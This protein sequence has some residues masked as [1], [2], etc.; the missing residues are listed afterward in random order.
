MRRISLGPFDRGWRGFG[1]E[2]LRRRGATRPPPGKGPHYRWP[3]YRWTDQPARNRD[4]PHG[5]TKPFFIGSA[6]LA[7]HRKRGV[8]RKLV[9][10]EIGGQG[11]VPKEC[12]LVI[13]KGEIAGRVTSCVY[14]AAVGRIIG[15]AYV[16]PHRRSQ[17]K[18]S[19]SAWTTAQW[20]RPTSRRR[21]STIRATSG[22]K[23]EP[24]HFDEAKLCFRSFHR[25]GRRC[26]CSRSRRCKSAALR[27]LP[28]SPVGD[29]GTRYVVL[30]DDGRCGCSERRQPG[31]EAKR[32]IVGRAIV[33]KRSSDP[34]VAAGWSVTP[35]RDD[36]CVAAGRSRRLLSS[37]PARQPLLVR[38]TGSD[39][40]R[41][42]AKLC[43]VNLASDKFTDGSVAQTSVAR[44]SAIVIRHD[45]ANSFSVS[46][47]AD[48]ASAE[49]L[50]SCV[51]DAMTEFSNS[52]GS[53]DDMSPGQQT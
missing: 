4:G 2:T 30:A 7:A 25:P 32:R 43:G 15:L 13:E 39:A 40:P 18:P 44:L 49:Y 26:V 8:R 50:W 33:A 28:P 12:H 52:I 5:S 51:L 37:A 34:F 19:R 42:F 6:A 11:P 9:G 45:I 22:N 14:S 1:F 3:G 47:L 38:I 21:R 17:G 36:R 27:S 41:M 48:S 29:Q 46:L 31:P 23:H 53:L 16:L 24:A 10:F 20:L 35:R